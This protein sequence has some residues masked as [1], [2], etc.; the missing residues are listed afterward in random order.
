MRLTMKQH[1]FNRSNLADLMTWEEYQLLEDAWMAYNAKRTPSYPSK[2]IVPVKDVISG[3]RP[4]NTIEN[5]I[6]LYA[7]W[8]GLYQ[9]ENIKNTGTWRPGIGYIPGRG[10]KGTADIS[11]TIRG[12]SVKI[13][14][15]YGKDRQSDDQK[16]YQAEVERAGGL[17]WIVRTFT[18]FM[19]QYNRLNNKRK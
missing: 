9:A 11:A 3:L 17:Y 14:V 8:T 1:H 5:C 18:D 13:E 6:V 10:Q 19:N 7:K 12:K 16:A 2:Y 4:S 15:K